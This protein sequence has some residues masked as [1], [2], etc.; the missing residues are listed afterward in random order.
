MGAPHAWPEAPQ[1]DAD[2][3]G[4]LPEQREDALVIGELRSRI[5]VVD[6]HLGDHDGQARGGERREVGR[7]GGRRVVLDGKRV[8]LEGNDIDEVFGLQQVDDRDVARHRGGV[9]GDAIFVEH[10]F[11]AREV[12]AGEFE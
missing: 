2:Y 8:P 4:V 7:Q 12:L 10:Q 6:I 1:G 9:V 3:G 5:R 11:L